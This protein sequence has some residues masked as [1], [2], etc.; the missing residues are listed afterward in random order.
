LGLAQTAASQVASRFDAIAATQVSVQP[1][2]TR[3]PTDGGQQSFT[4][5]P[6]DAEQR[7]ERLTG[8]LASGTISTIG[9]APPTRTIAVIDP[10]GDGS[11]ALPL[12]AVSPGLFDAVVGNVLTGRFFD[13]GHDTRADAVVVLGS[14]AAERLHINRVDNA[15][16]VFVGDRAFIVIGIVDH[17]VRH[18]ET[19]R[20]RHH[21]GAYRRRSSAWK[22]RR[23]ADS[24][25]RWEQL[26]WLAPSTNCA[27][28]N[29][30]S[31]I[32]PPCD[33][34]TEPALRV[35]ETTTPARAAPSR[36]CI[37]SPKK[38]MV[39]SLPTSLRLS[40]LVYPAAFVL[41]EPSKVMT[42]PRSFTTPF[43]APVGMRMISSNSPVIARQKFQHA[44]QPF[45]RV[46]H[47]PAGWT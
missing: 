24:A 19:A 15:P 16:T 44:L 36:P 25:R 29:D 32:N 35:K 45:P 31:L 34:R 12:V 28:P 33:S 30:P 17:V 40:L 5:V 13:K 22:R 46:R 21:P 23:C 11:Q 27:G 18:S 47:R 4:N 8:V 39:S 37:H 41:L 6:W 38:I 10:S 43:N 26:K 7:L 14:N 2:T 1:R 20:C 3:D 9:G 42:F